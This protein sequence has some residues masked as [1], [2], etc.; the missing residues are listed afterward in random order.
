MAFRRQVRLD[1]H[2]AGRAT[3]VSIVLL[4]RS[5]ARRR[6]ANSTDRRIDE[7][8][9][10]RP[11]LRTQRD[12]GRVGGALNVVRPANPDDRT[13]DSGMSKDP[14]ERDLRRRIAVFAADF[15]EE[16]NQRKILR[17]LRFDKLGFHA[18]CVI[19]GKPVYP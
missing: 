9:D 6:R 3:R 12:L 14:C 2:P 5:T 10:R 1:S 17:Q 19:T 15:V 11:R 18:P 13:R 4:V 16:M 7:A 8:I